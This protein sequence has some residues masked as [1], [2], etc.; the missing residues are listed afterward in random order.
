VSLTW[1]NN[2]LQ[3]AGIQ[4]RNGGVCV[5]RSAVPLLVNGM[6]VAVEKTAIGYVMRFNTQA[7]QF[8]L[9]TVK[10]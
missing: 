6:E 2:A 8:Y 4:S 3:R 1:Q 5:V 7:N 9:L 10:P